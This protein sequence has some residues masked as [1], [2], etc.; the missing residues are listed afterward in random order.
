MANKAVLAGA[1]VVS[2]GVVAY[3]AYSQYA[4]DQEE[5]AA[6]RESENARRRMEEEMQEQ[7]FNAE[8]RFKTS[9]LSALRIRV[10]IE[11][12]L[13]KL[14]KDA[15]ARIAA[16]DELCLPLLPRPHAPAL[17]SEA[18]L[19]VGLAFGC[20]L[21]D[22]PELV[23]GMIADAQHG[24]MGLAVSSLSCDAV[25][26]LAAF[27]D[28]HAA[29]PL[30]RGRPEL[31]AHALEPNN[32]SALLFMVLFVESEGPRCA[33]LKLQKHEV[34]AAVSLL[35][36]LG[37]DWVRWS[38]VDMKRPRPGSDVVWCTV[39]GSARS[40]GASGGVLELLVTNFSL[41]HGSDGFGLRAVAVQG[42]HFQLSLDKPLPC[43]GKGGRAS[44][45]PLLQP[46][47]DSCQDLYAA[48]FVA[49]AARTVAGRF[50]ALAQSELGRGFVHLEFLAASSADLP[51]LRAAVLAG[52]REH[53][54]L[55]LA[56]HGGAVRERLAQA[57][58][59][60]MPPPSEDDDAG[61]GARAAASHSAPST[62]AADDARTREEVARFVERYLR[63][64]ELRLQMVPR[65]RDGR[66]PADAV[67]ASSVADEAKAGI[68]QGPAVSASYRIAKLLGDDAAARDLALRKLATVPRAWEGAYRVLVCLL[69]LALCW[70]WHVAVSNV[71]VRLGGR[72]ARLLVSPTLAQARAAWHVGACA[73]AL[74]LLAVATSVWTLRRSLALLAT[75]LSMPRDA[76][77]AELSAAL[78]VRLY[79]LL[80]ARMG[81]EQ[82][83]ARTVRAQEAPIAA[84]VAIWRGRFAR[85]NF[86]AALGRQRICA[87]EACT[88]LDEL[89]AAQSAARAQPRRGR[90]RRARTRA[91]RRAARFRSLFRSRPVETHSAPGS[92][93]AAAPAPPEEDVGGGGDDEEEEQ[94]AAADEEAVRVPPRRGHERVVLPGTLQEAERF[95]AMPLDAEGSRAAETGPPTGRRALALAFASVGLLEDRSQPAQ[96]REPRAAQARPPTRFAV[97]TRVLCRTQ[98]GWE[99]ALVTELWPSPVQPYTLLLDSNKR[100]RATLDDDSVVRR[101]GPGVGAA[102]AEPAAR[103]RSQTVADALRERGWRPVRARRHVVFERTLANGAKQ[104]YVQAKTP[105]DRRRAQRNQ[106]ALLNRLEEAKHRL[107]EEAKLHRWLEP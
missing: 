4:H 48:L 83:V 11:K 43:R 106:L 24:L 87:S 28:E 19:A 97:G 6:K 5:A 89:A 47:P 32:W 91:Q 35:A 18:I 41:K 92:G 22:V 54:S 77:L 42:E 57:L 61:K 64:V 16:A 1:A 37:L 14:A 66:S 27:L 103:P 40:L 21:Y 63:L 3:N 84:T 58:L 15:A 44:A 29:Q 56:R 96:P 26:Q 71:L 80:A 98:R 10:V 85:R 74:W 45:C 94:A 86:F 88:L 105:S 101:H 51:T 52:M 70:L 60:Q 102:P 104:T 90:A 81:W 79:G 38:N 50:R 59:A 46:S 68:M 33:M 82:P 95:L 36:H 67:P 20:A 2:A 76:P 25:L 7:S 8:H 49:R 73:A 17:P 65:L 13:E 55:L 78:R 69:G 75:P 39:R 107:E 23:L 53:D 62:T 93:S 100:V 30:V 9:M 99:S 12:L 72:Y 31:T 34:E